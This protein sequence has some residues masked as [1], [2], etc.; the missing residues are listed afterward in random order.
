VRIG[1][2]SDTHDLVRPEARAALEGVAHIVHAGDVCGPEV[3][4]ALREIAP[5]SLVR[6][7]GT[8]EIGPKHLLW[9]SLSTSAACRLHLFA[10]G[11]VCSRKRS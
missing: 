10:V 1:L 3:I 9:S 4:A 5:V 7:I 11:P 8:R 6:A 2:L